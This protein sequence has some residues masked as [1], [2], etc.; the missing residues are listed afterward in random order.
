MVA[1]PIGAEQMTAMFNASLG[2]AS[3]PALSSGDNQSDRDR[4][5]YPVG[6]PWPGEAGRDAM[7]ASGCHYLQVTTGCTAHP[8]ALRDIATGRIL[9][10][11]DTVG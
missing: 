6:F 2:L 3:N 5:E 7:L 8:S 1:T 4:L 10:A 11:G 9:D